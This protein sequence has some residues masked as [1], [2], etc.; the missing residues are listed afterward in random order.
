MD[1]YTKATPAS[2]ERGGDPPASGSSCLPLL[3]VL[4]VVAI[5]VFA[6]VAA[7]RH[8]VQTRV[9]D[10]K[11]FVG[12][13]Q[14]QSL[15]RQS[16][17]GLTQEF[18]GIRQRAPWL[19]DEAQSIADFCQLASQESQI[20]LSPATWSAGCQREQTLYFGFDGNL[21]SRLGELQHVLTQQGWT[22]FA[23]AS[24]PSSQQ[25]RAFSPMAA[26]GPLVTADPGANNT[27]A[28]PGKISMEVGWIKSGSSLAPMRS[29]N[30]DATQ[31]RVATQ[32]YRPL[33][34]K[35]I[36]PATVV[37]HTLSTHRYLVAI[38][39]TLAYYESGG[40]SRWPS[41]NSN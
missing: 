34:L 1:H 2:S 37:E 7:I 33:E 18:A 13:S 15:D 35:P 31:S 20:V 41:G 4:A 32:S 14:L 27:I 29:L 16:R 25:G 28:V 39:V 21:A 23:P 9:P 6:V 12:S 3:A 30:A 24:G 17:T 40:P 22:D 38:Q 10:L 11:A 8:A 36:D 19:A 5:I 26:D